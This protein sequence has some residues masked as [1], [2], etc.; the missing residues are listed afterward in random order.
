M[1]RTYTALRAIHKPSFRS[2]VWLTLL[3]GHGVCIAHGMASSSAD[4]QIQ[5]YKQKLAANPR[6]YMVHSQLAGAY[7]D[8]ARETCD[9]GD[10]GRARH[11]LRRSMDIQPSLL[12]LKTMTALCN[13]S[14]RFE[15]ALQWG[16]RAAEIAPQDTSVI[17]QL[18]EAH[19]ALNQIEA[20]KRI[21]E[22]HNSSTK[23]FYLSAALGHC[24]FAEEQW[25]EASAWYLA[26]SKHAMNQQAPHLALWARAK[27]VSVYVAAGQLDRARK[28]L[29]VAGKSHGESEQLLVQQAMVMEAAG[30]F[31]GALKAYVEVLSGSH[32]PQIHAVAF[33]LAK[34]LGEESRARIHFQK[35]QSG[36]MK[37]VQAGEVYT[38]EILARLYLDSDLNTKRAVEFALRNYK[39]KRDASAQAILDTSQR[40]L[41]CE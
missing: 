32:N 7:L 30:E 5:F 38:L 1:A 9:P 24:L 19:L 41:H 40:R 31:G 4:E 25:D 16:Q 15:D 36:L 11:S 23:D 3:V 17:A 14:H 35:A 26:A 21:L 8:R 37:A 2:T 34:R 27:A 39:H 28:I 20:A 13:F 22:A 18:V 33:R 6:L 29:Q 10:V 12:A